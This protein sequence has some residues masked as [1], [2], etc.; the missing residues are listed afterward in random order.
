MTTYSN[1]DGMLAPF[2][3]GIQ[4]PLTIRMYPFIRLG[5][6]SSSKAVSYLLAFEK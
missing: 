2:I 4:V 5:S 6:K 1:L 3:A